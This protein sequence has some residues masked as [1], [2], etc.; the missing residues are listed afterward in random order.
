MSIIP[1]ILS[2]NS[3]NQK[4]KINYQ[5]TF[6]LKYDSTNGPY[7]QITSLEESLQRDFENLLLTNPGE[8]PMHPEIGIGLRTYLFNN[9]QGPE[10]A[11][12]QSRIVDQLRKYLPSIELLAMDLIAPGDNQDMNF[13]GIKLTYSILGKAVV[14]A[15]VEKDNFGNIKTEITSYDREFSSFR[16]RRSSLRSQMTQI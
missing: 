15:T 5:P 3:E 16:D 1:K 10:M 6:P 14:G 4:V 13:L 11:E 2:E 12:L 9:Y 7:A 8:W